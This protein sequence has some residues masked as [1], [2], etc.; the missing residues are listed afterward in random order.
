MTSWQGNLFHINCPLWG[1]SLRATNSR[2]V[3]DLRGHDT[4]VTLPFIATVQ[5]LKLLA[6]IRHW[7]V[8]AIPL[9]RMPFHCTVAMSFWWNIRHWLHR[10]LSFWQL[11]MQPV[12]KNL[13]I[14]SNFRFGVVKNRVEFELTKKSYF[15][16]MGELWVVYGQYSG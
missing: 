6:V 12:M 1:W 16:L 8:L 11:P 2:V 15:A 3:R 7:L 10:K 9:T 14:W 5:T 4:H 13:S